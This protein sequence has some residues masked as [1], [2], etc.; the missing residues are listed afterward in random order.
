MSS[1]LILGGVAVAVSLATYVH[2]RRAERRLRQAELLRAYTNDFYCDPAVTG[3]FM[4]V[5]HGRFAFG[6]AELGTDA[7]LALIRLLD[8]FNIVGHNWKQD[9]LRL[10]DIVPTPPS[11]STATPP[12]SGTSRRSKS[13]TNNGTTLVPD[14]VTSGNSPRRW[15]A[16]VLGIGARPCSPASESGHRPRRRSREA[17]STPAHELTG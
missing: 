7:E 14:S 1:E 6:D 17:S 15:K 16:N 5:D 13:G 2:G 10:D 4:D 3:I 12:Y 9:V 8:F 11:A